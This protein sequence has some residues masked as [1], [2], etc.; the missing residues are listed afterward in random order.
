MAQTAG[1]LAIGNWFT[2]LNMETWKPIF[3]KAAGFGAGGVLT[4]AICLGL[5]FWYKSR[6]ARPR[7]WDQSAITAQFY[8]VSTAAEGDSKLEFEYVLQ[9]N[10]EK[11]Y[12]LPAYSAPKIA[13]KLQD[14]KSF[15]GFAD[16]NQFLLKLP[17]FVPAHQKTRIDVTLPSYGFSSAI[18]LTS[19]SSDDER[20]KYNAAV[21]AYV[22]QKMSNLDGFV[23]FDENN[24]YEIELP[25]GWK[26][27]YEDNERESKEKR[28]KDAVKG[29]K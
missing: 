12:E 28:E 18:H 21:G 1:L 27:E 8:R 19:V 10:S 24:R 23:L 6:P 20:R 16:Q 13:A 3:L 22:A 4:A 29:K 17:I 11:D 7:P 2:G 26:R 25:N 14:T 5:F 9:N 15:A